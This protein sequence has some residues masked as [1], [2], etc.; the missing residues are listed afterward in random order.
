MLK[1]PNIQLSIYTQTQQGQYLSF[2]RYYF[3][4][5]LHVA[6]RYNMT[7]DSERG[8][9]NPNYLWRKRGTEA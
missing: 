1:T 5:S 2:A 6:N 3:M 7:F 9:T 4:E 8:M